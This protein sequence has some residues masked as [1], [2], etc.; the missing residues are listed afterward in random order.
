MLPIRTLYPF[1]S[2]YIG[3]RRI[4]RIGPRSPELP[5]HPG[6]IP[7]LLATGDSQQVVG[8]PGE[9][10]LAFLYII[11]SLACLCLCSWGDQRGLDSSRNCLMSNSSVLRYNPRNL[12]PH[13]LF[14]QYALY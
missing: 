13:P 1:L 10:I 2:L 8:T 6:S 4:E 11:P 9:P 5:N 7:E 12:F 14:P 3:L